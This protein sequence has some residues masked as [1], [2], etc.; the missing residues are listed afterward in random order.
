V[1]GSGGPRLRPPWRRSATR[2]RTVQ[3]D[4]ASGRDY[5]SGRH[6]DDKE[7]GGCGDRCNALGGLDDEP[8]GVLDLQGLERQQPVVRGE[9]CEHNWELNSA[10]GGLDSF[11]AYQSTNSGD[12]YI[13][14]SNSSGAVRVN[15]EAGSGAAFKV[16]GGNSSS[17]YASLTG[18]TAIQFPG[19][20]SSNGYSCLQIDTSDISPT[21]AQP[22]AQATPTARSRWGPVRLLP[23]MPEQRGA[24][25]R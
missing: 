15:Y 1:I 19:L 13:N 10:I 21:P 18:T 11:K 2:E 8:E 6:A 22:A 23:T 5:N 24:F 7:P 20:K 4:A 17:V 25:F 3:R 14:A 16:Y 9:G 12:T